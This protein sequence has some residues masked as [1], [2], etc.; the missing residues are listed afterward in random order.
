MMTTEK[1]HNWT[2]K[3]QGDVDIA[4]AGTF[5][6]RSLII[7]H[8]Q[9]NKKPDFEKIISLIEKEKLCFGLAI[10]AP[11]FSFGLCDRVKSYSLYYS[12]KTGEI[13]HSTPDCSNS[14]TD[15]YSILEFMMAGYV[16]GNRTLYKDYRQI[17]GGE[18]VF[19][20]K[21][22]VAP[23]ITNTRYYRYRP[24]PVE[25]GKSEEEY[26]EEFG[27]IM[28]DAILRSLETIGDKPILIPL[29]GGLDSRIVLGKLHEHGARN[30]KTFSYGIPNN[31]EA[32]MAQKAAAKLGVEWRMVPSEPE[33]ARALYQSQTRIE[34]TKAMNGLCH[35]PS[36]VEFEAFHTLTRDNLYS[37]DS[38]IFNGQAGDYIA[39]N[40]IPKV[41]YDN[42][43]PTL[44]DLIRYAL[45]KHFSLWENLKTP[46]NETRIADTIK[47][48]LLEPDTK[49]SEKD[50]LLRQ[51]ESFEWQERQCKMVTHAQKIYDYF[52]FDWRLPLWDK[53][54]MDFFETLPWHL[55]F[56]RK[57]FRDYVRDWNYMGLF[58][59]M[60]AEPE[61]WIANKNRIIWTARIIGLLKGANAKAD[62]Y[63]QMAYFNDSHWQYALFGKDLYDRHYK[64]M[65]NMISLAVLQYCQEHNI[66]NPKGFE[67]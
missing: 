1:K 57:L 36:Y 18:F 12:E 65:R 23:Q 61:P 42:D 29:S 40:H 66:D 26:R 54:I 41:L 67:G 63:K 11:E 30:I 2:L 9:N 46:E 13:F 35:I 20:D 48:L 7:D 28:D 43:A 39:G 19:V 16:L 8:L 53:D 25:M 51:Y 55:K 15:S 22:G 50:N 24:T 10:N 3:K 34:Y 37:K 17:R 33:N 38:V 31:F 47:S 5:A 4:Y 44:D 21:R 6:D 49:H 14:E 32:K 64:N 56:G 52:G 27:R 45:D 59:E 58:D 62:Y 60:S